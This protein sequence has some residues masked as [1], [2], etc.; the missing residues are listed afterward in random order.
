MTKNNPS[1]KK[2]KK[3][4]PKASNKKINKDNPNLTIQSL[5]VN[6]LTDLP[7]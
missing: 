2:K 5:V 3:L 4:F 7:N 1:I 6:Q